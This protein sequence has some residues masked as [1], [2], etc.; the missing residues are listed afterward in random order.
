MIP[1]GVANE[2]PRQ[3][4]LQYITGNVTPLHLAA[5]PIVVVNQSPPCIDE[6][7]LET[8]ES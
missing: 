4:L 7:Y 2:V 6:R 8:N 5:N 3:R 1:S